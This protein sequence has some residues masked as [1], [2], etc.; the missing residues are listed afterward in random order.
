MLSFSS[1]KGDDIDDDNINDADNDT[2][3]R[4]PQDWS[5]PCNTGRPGDAQ[6]HQLLSA[7][8]LEEDLV[9]FGKTWF[10]ETEESCPPCTVRH[11]AS[12]SGG[13]ELTWHSYFA[14]SGAP[15]RCS[16]F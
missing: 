4:Q 2:P 6:T 12:L 7:P 9:K 15:T 13:S 10:A 3:G 11:M 8:E 5:P 16:Y 14:S 1:F